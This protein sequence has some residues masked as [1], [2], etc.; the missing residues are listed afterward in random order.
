MNEFCQETDP[1]TGY[2]R[3]CS[4]IVVGQELEELKVTIGDVSLEP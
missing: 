4:Q 1:K 3:P 2:L